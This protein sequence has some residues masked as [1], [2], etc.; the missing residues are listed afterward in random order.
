MLLI[1]VVDLHRTKGTE[2]WDACVLRTLPGTGINSAGS[3]FCRPAPL[4]WVLRPPLGC[5]ESGMRPHRVPGAASSNDLQGRYLP[6]LEIAKSI[7]FVVHSE[8]APPES[9]PGLQ[10]MISILDAAVRCRSGWR[11]DRMAGN[12]GP[13][14]LFRGIWQGPSLGQSVLVSADYFRCA[15]VAR[16]AQDAVVSNEL[17]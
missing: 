14:G 5:V 9:N 7:G 1:V 10:N 8:N 4:H 15:Y 13:Q 6:V 3:S 12:L 11:G 17:R 16:M 2:L